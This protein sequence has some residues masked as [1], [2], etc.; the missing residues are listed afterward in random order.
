MFIIDFDDTLVDTRIGYSQARI[1]ALEKIGVSE[2]M[3]KKSYLEARAKNEI[4]VYNHQR[5]AKI[6]ESYGFDYDTIYSILE[7]FTTKKIL[8]K[9]LFSDSI[10]FLNLSL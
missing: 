3:H 10:N 1:K 9:Y 4:I 7:Q 8:K 2:N 5:H 6:L